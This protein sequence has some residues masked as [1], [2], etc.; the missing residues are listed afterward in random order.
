[1]NPR[2]PRTPEPVLIRTPAELESFWRAR[3]GPLGFSRPALWLTVLVDD[4]TTGVLVEISDLPYVPDSRDL[5]GFRMLLDELV[6][7]DRRA[8]VA[9]LL[10][11]PGGGGPTSGDRAWA[12]GLVRAAQGAGVLVA[13]VHLATDHTLGAITGEERPLAG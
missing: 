13:P 8:R 2:S 11:R 10:V 12:D 7:G 4:T 3:M 5:E 9:L 1:M 6:G